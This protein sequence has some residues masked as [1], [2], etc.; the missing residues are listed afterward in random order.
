MG[1]RPKLKINL[2][3]TWGGHG[4]AL[5]T[6]LVLMPYILHTI[7]DETYGLWVFLNSIAGYS[8]LLYLGFGETV[9]RYVAT[10]HARKEFDRMNQT[11]NVIFAIFA[12][13]AAVT[14]VVAGVVAWLAPWLHDWEGELIFEIRAVIVI[15]GLN[16]AVGLV[17]SVFG[18]VLEGIQ[19]FDLDGG[20]Q[21]VCCGIRLGLTFGFLQGEYGLLTLA[22]IYFAITLF[23]NLANV[24]LAFRLLPELSIRPRYFDRPVLRECCSF[25]LFAF[26]NTAAILLINAT[27]TIVIG[28][29]FGAKAIVPY[30]L[31]AR[32]CQFIA[33]P[34]QAIGTISMPR[35]GELHAQT[36]YSSLQQLVLRGITFAFVLSMGAFIG[37]GFF[38]THA[39]ETW[40]G[41]GYESSHVILLVL[42]GS[43]IIANPMGVMRQVLFGMGHVRFPALVHV[44]EAV[45]NIVLSLILLHPLGLL[46]I[47]LGTAI[48]T[49][50]VELFVLL[51]YGMNKLGIDLGRLV[52]TALAPM[53]F[54]LVALWLYSF[55]V[56]STFVIPAGWV[57]LAI[58]SVG[59]GV[60]L[61]AAWCAFLHV[62]K[63]FQSR[64]T[65]PIDS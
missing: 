46:G 38:G 19:R 45:A 24:V 62:S 30:Y 31:A 4:L 25:S 20:L 36:E 8:S 33:M 58:V 5:V 32:L 17:G 41:P 59:G 65:G 7:G 10:H 42:L 3:S 49:I 48:P 50:V 22:L 23:E 27:D 11:V 37:A 44:A 53:L 14:M 16:I 6:G 60:I 28:L 35:A 26:L 21:F 52:R 9:S 2:L 61:T 12:G 63:Y 64:T 43:R 29:I 34:I 55:V 51:P 47:A 56:T 57:E 39:F 1:F 18:G 15:L 54:P 13:M 40:V